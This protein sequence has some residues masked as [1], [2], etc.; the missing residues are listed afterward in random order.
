M[1]ILVLFIWELTLPSPLPPPSPLMVWCLR[2]MAVLLGR[3]WFK[4]TCSCL[5][6][7]G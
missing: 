3:E 6:L 4:C 5:E 1:N 2:E 7:V